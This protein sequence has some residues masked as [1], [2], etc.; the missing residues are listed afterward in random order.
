M[1]EHV[2]DATDADLAL[3]KQTLPASGFT[4]VH[5]AWKV[6]LVRAELWLRMNEARVAM[7]RGLVHS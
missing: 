1:C 3:W 4:T 5:V 2:A 6:H 7:E